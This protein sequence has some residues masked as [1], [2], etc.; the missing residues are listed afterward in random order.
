V[1]AGTRVTTSFEF[2]AAFP[3]IGEAVFDFVDKALFVVGEGIA[4]AS[5]TPHGF[6]L[7]LAELG[8]RHLDLEIG[9]CGR[10]AA[11]TPASNRAAC[12]SVA[13]RHGCI[14]RRFSY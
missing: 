12:R 2:E 4:A 9:Q 13:P 8:V 3:E 6:D 10:G 14:W 7:Q 11:T 5:V 1:V